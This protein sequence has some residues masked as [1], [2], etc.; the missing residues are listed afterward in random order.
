[1]RRNPNDIRLL[2]LKLQREESND[3]KQGVSINNIYYEITFGDKKQT[4]RDDTINNIKSPQ[5]KIAWA[6]NSAED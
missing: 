1:V 3:S 4:P 6:I 5:Q 2:R